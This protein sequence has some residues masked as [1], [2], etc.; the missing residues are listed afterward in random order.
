MHGEIIV[1]SEEGIGT[2]VIIKL[3]FKLFQT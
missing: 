1:E 2:E 3:P